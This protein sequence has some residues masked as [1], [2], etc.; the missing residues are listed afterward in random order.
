RLF[1]GPASSS[2]TTG[3]AINDDY[4][5]IH[6][7]LSN[8]L[9]DLGGGN[10]T[11]ILGVS[12]GYALNL[13]NAEHL[14]GSAGDDFVTLVNNASGLTVDLGAAVT[15]DVLTLAGGANSLSLTNVEQ[16]NSSDLSGAVVT[17]DVLT[18]QNNVSGLT[19]NLG[20]GTNTLNLAAGTN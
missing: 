6:S 5:K 17:S 16:V 12:G 10:D 13:A 19:V 3:P 7:G 20:Q 8:H 1:F 4:I 11:V 15:G 14:I 2:L 9:I 18:L